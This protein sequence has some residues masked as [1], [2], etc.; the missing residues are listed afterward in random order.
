MTSLASTA[1]CAGER[2]PL[3]KA[4][5]SS[6][7]FLGTGPGS[8][9]RGKFFSSCLLRHESA[10]VLV[11]A[12]EPCSQRLVEAGVSAADI[13]AVLLTHA[14]SDHTA[15]LP[16]LLQSAWL[17]PRKK[18]LSLFLPKELVKPLQAW[19]EAVYLPPSLLGFALSF[20][21]WVAGHPATVA[22]EVEVLPFPTTHLQSLRRVIEP[23]AS[24]RF[25]IFALDVRCGDKRVV[26]S[27]DLGSPFDL[28][29]ALLS[30]CDVL[31]CELSHFAP[32]EL[33]AFLDGK[34]IGTLVLNHLAPA[35]A[36]SEAMVCAEAQKALPG[37]RRVV[38]PADG[39]TVEF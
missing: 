24:D 7:Q 19:L 22:R 1:A 39:E 29:P 32:G 23:S 20:H 12:G 3:I 28:E 25:E 18:P 34:K 16:M 33:F 17:S 26:F 2:A 38:V 4:A 5:V 36:G 35:L 21:P 15:G 14:H 30:P 13:D 31:V 8:P 27:S 10:L 37:L 11:D 9:V 6:L